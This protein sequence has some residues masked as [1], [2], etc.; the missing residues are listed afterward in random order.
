MYA[1]QAASDLAMQQDRMDNQQNQNQYGNHAPAQN[2]YSSNMPSQ[3]GY[4]NSS[5]NRGNNARTA[6]PAHY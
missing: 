2:G 4:G 5:P 3:S 1:S 6:Q